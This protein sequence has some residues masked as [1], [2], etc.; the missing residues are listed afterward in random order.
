MKFFDLHCDTLYEIYKKNQELYENSCH[1]SLK[2]SKKIKN[3]I[4][5][6]AFWMPD[7]Y[8]GEKAVDFFKKVYENFKKEEAKNLSSLK[9]IKSLADIY[10]LTG[11]K[12]GIILTVEGGSVLNGELERVKKLYDLGIRAITLTWNGQNEIGDG[13][14]V[15]NPKG[16]SEFGIKAVKEMEKHKIIVDVSHASKELFFDVAAIAKRPFIAT[17]SNS[18]SICRHK[19]NLT[20]EQFRIIKE[21]GGIVGVTFCKKF[22]NSGKDAEISDIMKHI[23]Y[24]LSLGGEKILGIGSDFDGTDIPGGI[25]GIQDIELL[26]E[27][28]LRH[29][30]SE[31][32]VEDIFYNN[33]YNFFERM[34]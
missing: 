5:C 6:F 30:Y 27:Y 22:L 7:E 19:R 11:Q 32:L 33:A 14:E 31:K 3:Y 20:D 18:Y 15:I 34:L 10:E 2:R 12:T 17:H 28:L 29:N 25:R 8:R 16:I 24:F 26:Y 21:K 23:E 13:N 9:V 4:G 1:V